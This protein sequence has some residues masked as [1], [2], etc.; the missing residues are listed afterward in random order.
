MVDAG[1]F[2][3]R[4]GRP[5]ELLEWAQLF[6]DDEYRKVAYTEVAD[7]VA[8]STIWVGMGGSLGRLFETVVFVTLDAPKRCL[9]REL[10]REGVEEHRWPTLHA[11]RAG[12]DQVV[13]ELKGQF[14]I[15]E[16]AHDGHGN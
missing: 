9:G 13:A 11:A 4:D 16:E 3:D 7:G 10:W 15:K 6:E 14:D 12:H 5:L 1:R 2:F 8:V